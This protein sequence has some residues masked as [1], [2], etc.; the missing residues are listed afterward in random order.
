MFVDFTKLLVS[1]QSNLVRNISLSVIY[2]PPSS[3][4]EQPLSYEQSID[5]VIDPT[6]NSKEEEEAK[7]GVVR[8]KELISGAIVH[9]F[10]SRQPIELYSIY[11]EAAQSTR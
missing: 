6:V 10:T 4:S 9:A 1:P 3:A 8:S 7:E 11:S 5:W 2:D